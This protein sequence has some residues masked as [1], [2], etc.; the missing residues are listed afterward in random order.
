[1][2]QQ[3]QPAL[4]PLATIRIHKN[5]DTQEQS[6]HTTH[7]ATQQD[8][9]KRNHLGRSETKRMVSFQ[10]ESNHQQHDEMTI[11]PNYDSKDHESKDAMSVISS[12]ISSGTSIIQPITE[13][14]SLYDSHSQHRVGIISSSQRDTTT[15]IHHPCPEV[16]YTSLEQDAILDAYGENLFVNH[17]FHSNR[18]FR[19]PTTQAEVSKLFRHVDL[20]EATYLFGVLTVLYDHLA[21]N[22][23]QDVIH[24]RSV[25]K[26]RFE[27]AHVAFIIM[28]LFVIVSI[29]W[30]T[31]ASIYRQ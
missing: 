22:L 23:L 12:P 25:I 4:V 17:Y 1:M 5:D 28:F 29:V 21:P 14:P 6:I 30:G 9:L 10:V 15:T 19:I 24:E 16:S 27:R 26:V 8:D 31:S 13:S 11:D 18:T 2:N 3:H 7:M 20:E